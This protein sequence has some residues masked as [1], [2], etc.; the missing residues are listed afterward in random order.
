MQLKITAWSPDP[1]RARKL[2]YR[3]VLGWLAATPSIM[4]YHRQ[5]R[6]AFHFQL[7]SRIRMALF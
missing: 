3:A 6:F 1:K 7:I 2:H 4:E 5:K